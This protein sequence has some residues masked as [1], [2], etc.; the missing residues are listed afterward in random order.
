MPPDCIR[1]DRMAME[2]PPRLRRVVMMGVIG[3]LDPRSALAVIAVPSTRVLFN[4]E[5]SAFQGTM[6]PGYGFN[7]FRAHEG[8]TECLAEISPEESEG[9]Q[10]REPYGECQK[11][12]RLQRM[13]ASPSQARGGDCGISDD[14]AGRTSLSRSTDPG[15]TS[16]DTFRRKNQCVQHAGLPFQRRETTSGCVARCEGHPHHEL[17][18]SCAV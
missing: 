10:A 6:C 13:C 5:G 14:S 4:M 3:C 15:V 17:R 7:R 1:M 16:R 11:H 12:P 9:C 8:S 18:I 2:N